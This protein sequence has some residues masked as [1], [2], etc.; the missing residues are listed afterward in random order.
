MLP[1]VLHFP[2][3]ARNISLIGLRVMILDIIAPH[4]PQITSAEGYDITERL[5]S[6]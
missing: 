5:G 2:P 3:W 6:H 1:H 4:L